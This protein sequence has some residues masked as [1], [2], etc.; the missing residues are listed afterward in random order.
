MQKNVPIQ[1]FNHINSGKW[2]PQKENKAATAKE[3]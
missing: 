2:S 3:Q 1:N